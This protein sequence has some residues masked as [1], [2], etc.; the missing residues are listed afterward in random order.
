LLASGQEH[1]FRSPRQPMLRGQSIALDGARVD[2]LRT[3]EGLP[4]TLRVTFD[5]SLDDPSLRLLVSTRDGLTAFEPPRLHETRRVPRASHPSW[6]AL[7]RSRE[8]RRMGKPPELVRFE[9]VPGFVKYDPT[10]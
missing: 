10:L 7:Q 9:P 6:I 5:R 4:Q 1:M 2:V 3:R 8:E